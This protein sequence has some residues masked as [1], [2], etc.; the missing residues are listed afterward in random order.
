MS[1][2]GVSIKKYMYNTTGAGFNQP[3]DKLSP[4]LT[5]HTKLADLK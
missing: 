2:L 3:V 1:F 4:T 5:Q